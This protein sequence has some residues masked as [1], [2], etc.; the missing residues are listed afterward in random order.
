MTDDKAAQARAVALRVIYLWDAPDVVKQYLE[1]GDPELSEEAYAEAALRSRHYERTGFG[2]AAADA[3]KWACGLA[4]DEILLK[5]ALESASLALTEADEAVLAGKRMVTEARLEM[6]AAIWR[7]HQ[8]AGQLTSL[9]KSR[10]D[11]LR[12]QLTV[13]VGVTESSE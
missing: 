10:R 9:V 11:K 4:A 5:G 6:E 8:K 2:Q 12:K 1:T 3:A 7:Y 13:E